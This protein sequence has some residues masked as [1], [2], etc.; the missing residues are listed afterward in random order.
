MAPVRVKSLIKEERLGG[1]GGREGGREGE[2][3]ICTFTRRACQFLGK[4]KEGGKDGRREG[5]REGG[6]E[7]RTYLSVSL[8]RA[9]RVTSS[10]HF[11]RS[12]GSR[13]EAR[14]RKGLVLCLKTSC[15]NSTALRVVLSHA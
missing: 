10:S 13:Q 15:V 11:F 6:R 7:G 3:S 2:V 1:E 12:S 14:R 4:R 5:G 9:A 8:P